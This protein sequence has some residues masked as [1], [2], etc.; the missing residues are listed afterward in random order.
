MIGAEI[1]KKDYAQTLARGLA[2]LEVLAD[3]EVPLGCTEVAV[4]M[5]VSRAAAR[6][7]LLTLA[8]RGYIRDAKGLYT[9]SPKLLALGRGMLARGSLWST[10]ALEVVN[11]ANRFNEP[12]SVSVLDGMN[13]VFVCRD[14]TRRMFS[15]RLGVGDWL[16]AHCSASGKML[17][18]LLPDKELARRLAG[19]TLQR[20]G[21]ASLTSV[22]AL[23]AALQKVRTAGFAIAVDEM[24]DGTVSIAVPLRGHDDR[25]IA[26]MSVASHRSRNEPLKLEKSVLPHLRA[27]AKQVETIIR[28]F[29]ERKCTV[30]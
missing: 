5:K 4:A 14:S 20:Q 2:C 10:V 6:R 15:N 24:E 25:A 30:L 3:A 7:I 22:A 28:D 1:Q 13:I 27:T 26:A 18:S 21:P 8:Y 23:K 19:I 11:L 16:P 9:C 29:Q 12:C 17:L